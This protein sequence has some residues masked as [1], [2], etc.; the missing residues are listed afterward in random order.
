MSAYQQLIRE[1]MARLGRIG[2]AD[3]RHVEGYMRLE[4]S[5]LDGLSPRQFDDEVEIGIECVRADGTTNAEA[6]AQSF[7]L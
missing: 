3:P 1:T 7:G 2:A 4:H 6:L 5:T